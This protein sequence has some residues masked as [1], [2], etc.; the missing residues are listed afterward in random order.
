[1][2]LKGQIAL[3]TGSSRGIGRRI[4]VALARE[5]ADVILSA[6][7]VNPG[8]GDHP[9]SLQ[10]VAA[11]CEAA[12]VKAIQLKC[13]LT[14]EDDVRRMCRDALQ[15][16]GRVDIVVNNGAYFS[17]DQHYTPFLQ[18]RWENW[19]NYVNANLLAPVLVCRELL[20]PMI[21][22]KHGTIIN[23]TSSLATTEMAALPGKGGAAIAYG[24]VKG[25]M[26]RFSQGLAKE[27]GV[28]AI[29][30]ILVDPGY[31]L[32]ERV[33]KNSGRLGGLDTSQAHSMELA[34]RTVASLCNHPNIMFFNG[35]TV[36]AADYVREHNL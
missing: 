13:D 1:M 15:R 7:T 23:I 34:A 31:T 35:K 27:T 36:V 9:G 5:G 24:A 11:E 16:C 6:R 12:G 28:H 8:T 4:A 3:V 29:P 25:G 14:V 17:E 30:T 33:E 2:G 19:H 26:H 18:F 20:A 10:E 22:R 32:T 21:E